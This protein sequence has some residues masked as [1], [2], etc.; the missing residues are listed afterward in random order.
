MGKQLNKEIKKKRRVNYIKRKKALVQ[1]KIAAA[2][3]A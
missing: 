1:T 2:K 3:K